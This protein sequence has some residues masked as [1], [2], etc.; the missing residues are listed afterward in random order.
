MSAEPQER[1]CRNCN[2][3][4]S[5][6]TEKVFECGYLTTILTKANCE[7]FCSCTTF[8]SKDNLEYLELK[9]KQTE[10]MVL[11]L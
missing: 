4:E 9:V 6:H 5:R 8:V 1:I 3:V 10:D 2:H 11:H 7:S